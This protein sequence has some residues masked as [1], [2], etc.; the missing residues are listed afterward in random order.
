MKI[1]FNQVVIT[2]LITVLLI[3]LACSE[4]NPQNGKLQSHILS[5]KQVEKLL[6]KPIC[7]KSY[8][9][10]DS[11]YRKALMQI[12]SNGIELYCEL[13]LP[14]EGEKFPLL[15][16][17]HG[18]F[19]NFEEIM[20][21]PLGDAPIYAHCGYAALVYHK[22][23]TGKSGGDYANS[24]RNDFIN[25]I[26]NIAKYFYGYSLID[27]TKIGVAGGS[28]GGLN[29]PVAAARFAEISFVVSESGPIVS[30]EEESNYNMKNA[31]KY[32]GYPDSLIQ[33]VMP[34]W[35]KQHSLWA[36][37]DTAQLKL[38]AKEIVD[39]REKYDFFLIPSTYNE[40]YTD[41]NLSFLRPE[42]T[43]MCQEVYKE[44]GYLNKKFL[45]IYGELDK[46]VPVK[47][48]VKN[49]QKF[50]EES[51]N[52]EYSIIVLPDVDHSFFYPGTN[53]QIPAMN[54]II[55]WLNENVQLDN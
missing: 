30:E 29:G 33:Q 49:T 42:F 51:G 6:S 32:R 35:K 25:D 11:S 53:K 14:L 20:R 45:S 17:T 52:N 41:T 15:I 40:I 38:F 12:T 27:K 10:N 43:S 48:S 31:L 1:R 39:L 9:R 22:R 46:I 26:G 34:Y 50:M 54:I 23:G 8:K 21:S 55:N 44:L 2:I 24:T 18:G 3:N 4:H 7:M 13:Y 5:E 47:E 19:N 16:L 36:K 28:G 37:A